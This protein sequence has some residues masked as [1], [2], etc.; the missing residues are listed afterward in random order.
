LCQLIESQ[1]LVAENQ[2]PAGRFI[3][4]TNILD[5]KELNASEILKIYKQQQSCV[6]VACRLGKEDLGF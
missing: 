6:R 2:N 4:A 5:I 3:L 1:E